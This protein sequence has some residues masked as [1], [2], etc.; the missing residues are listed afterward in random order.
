[1]VDVNRVLVGAISCLN[2]RSK[3]C[4]RVMLQDHS[5]HHRRQK[6]KILVELLGGVKPIN[7]DGWRFSVALSLFRGHFPNPTS[8]QWWSC[9]DLPTVFIVSSGSVERLEGEGLAEGVENQQSFRYRS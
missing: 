4:F 7:F 6:N 9:D 2:L 8:T 5:R 3:S 1:M